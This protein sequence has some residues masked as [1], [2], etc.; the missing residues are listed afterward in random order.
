MVHFVLE[1]KFVENIRRINQNKAQEKALEVQRQ[2]EAQNSSIQKGREGKEE[3]ERQSRIELM[4]TMRYLKESSILEL[5]IEFK[6]SDASPKDL[7]ISPSKET[8]DSEE[9]MDAMVKNE[10][11]QGTYY[12]HGKKYRNVI[13]LEMRWDDYSSETSRNYK[14]IEFCFESNGNIKVFSG[15]GEAKIPLKKW[16]NN[17]SI[18]DNAIERA[19]LNPI[20]NNYEIHGEKGQQDG[21]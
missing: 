8:L 14:C 19:Y 16:Q 18:L 9:F 4:S 3:L 20:M 17:L 12:Y 11:S 10:A 6:N 5:L 21:F 1:P 15:K 13:F 2:A 7:K